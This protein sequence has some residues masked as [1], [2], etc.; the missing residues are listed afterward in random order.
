MFKTLLHPDDSSP[1]CHYSNTYINNIGISLGL[2][3]YGILEENVPHLANLALE[4]S[5]HA[6]HPFPVTMEDFT[7]VY[8]R[9]L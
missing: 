1:L 3:E 8:T 2:S 9:A 5:C 4:D 7:A 6:A